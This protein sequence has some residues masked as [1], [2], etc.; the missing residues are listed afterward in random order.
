MN[1]KAGMNWI[2]LS[3]LSAF[4]LATADACTKRYLSGESPEALVLIRFGI[5]G[6]LLLPILFFHPIPAVPT[7]FWIWTLSAVPLEIIA[8]LL[9]MRAIQASPL[10]LT[11]PYLAFTPVFTVLIAYVMLGERISSRGLAGIALITLGAFL[12]NGDHL[13]KGLTAPFKAIFEEKGSRL[14]LLVAL[15]YSLTSVLGK[16]SLRYC[17]PLSFG[18][19]YFFLVG[20]ATIAVFSIWAPSSLKRIWLNPYPNFFVGAMM[21]VM[22]LSHFM[23]LD[24][25][26]VA[27]M[28]AVKRTSLLF[29][30]LYGALLFGERRFGLS[31]LAGSVMIAGVALISL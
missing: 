6:L 4:T 16:G 26:N 30:I 5:P 1:Y 13:K 12:L 11:L 27:Y 8:M 28:I 2:L 23:A 3:L 14:M 21:V 29:G 17:P 22:V 7:A 10:N 9:Y 19:F 15:I 25:S 18:A 24:L 31:I 20:A